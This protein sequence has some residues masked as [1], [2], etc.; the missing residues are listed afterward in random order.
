[1]A[2]NI[3]SLKT[4]DT[5]HYIYCNM[6]GQHIADSFID[7]HFIED[8]PINGDKAV[9]YKTVLGYT[10]RNAALY[11]DINPENPTPAKINKVVIDLAICSKTNFVTKPS[12]TF[13]TADKNNW[14]DSCVEVRKEKIGNRYTT[15]F[16]VTLTDG[17]P[18]DC[19]TCSVRFY[20]NGVFIYDA[21]VEYNGVDYITLSPT[22]ANVA[23]G[24]ASVP[25]RI[26]SNVDW[27]VTSDQT[28]CT[29]SP[30][31][32]T[33]GGEVAVTVA[34]N[35][36][37]TSRTAHVKVKSPNVH[38]A[39]MTITQDAGDQ[40]LKVTPAS[41]D[42]NYNSSEIPC[43]VKSN[44]TWYVDSNGEWLKP[45]PTE[46]QNNAHI[47]IHAD[48]NFT[49]SSRNATVT[50]HN[51]GNTITDTLDVSQGAYSGP[52]LS[53][54]PTSIQ[55]NANGTQKTVDVF[56]NKSWSV[57]KNQNWVSITPSASGTNDGRFTVTVD[58]NPDVTQRTATITVN[59]AGNADTSTISVTQSG[60]QAHM[61][62]TPDSLSFPC[63]ESSNT[64]TIDSNVNWTIS[65]DVEW[66]YLDRL[67]GDHNATVTVN[68]DAND[69]YDERS[70]TLTIS[71]PSLSTPKTVTV[72]QDAS[73]APTEE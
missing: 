37:T 44:I 57:S 65:R 55:S 69:T 49:A 29:V 4:K 31:S 23:K 33:N 45:F 56:S 26:T 72:T 54:T 36:L 40:K 39:V 70:A 2:T 38:D 63:D 9:C 13:N 42:I 10:M 28:W 19:T 21:Y 53:V 68:V 8:V 66:C 41:I 3:F 27:T 52:S 15:Y 5:N 25:L 67:I 51:Q 22:S 17:T 58:S 60:G 24:G 47:S 64:F 61:T 11:F 30:A 34:E 48:K 59:T 18:N 50:F 14:N 7:A 46:G 1:M 32:G 12:Y 6:L 62:V 43:S 16:R 35:S 73:V 20:T 71:S